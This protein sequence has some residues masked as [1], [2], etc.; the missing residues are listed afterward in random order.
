LIVSWHAANQETMAKLVLSPSS[1]APVAHELIEELIT[2]GRAPDN[3]IQ[4]DDPSVS[5]RHAQISCVGD[6]FQLQDLNSTNGTRVNDRTITGVTALQ[7]G[8]RLR[9]GKIEA[10]FECETPSHAQPLPTLT[11]VEA[12]PA[13]VSTRPTDFANASPFSRRKSPRDL[14]QTAIFAI[15]AIAILAFLGSIIALMQMQPPAP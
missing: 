12:K 9:F 2:I 13:A 14:M 10:R 4:I 6:I 15:V 8:D 11:A 1:S 7:A 3:L 5:G